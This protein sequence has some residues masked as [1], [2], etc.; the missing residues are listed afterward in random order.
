MDFYI[1]DLGNCQR[2]CPDNSISTN[3]QLYNTNGLGFSRAYYGIYSVNYDYKLVYGGTMLSYSSYESHDICLPVGCYIVQFRL[4]GTNPNDLLLEI[5]GDKFGYTET[6]YVCIDE[7]LQCTVTFLN[8]PTASPTLAIPT[9]VA[10]FAPTIGSSVA[11]SAIQTIS[12]CSSDEYNI[13]AEA[14]QSTIKESIASC[15]ISAGM[16]LFT[17]NINDFRVYPSPSNPLDLLEFNISYTL[18][19]PLSMNIPSTTLSSQLTNCVHSGNFTSYL[20]KFVSFDGPENLAE[21]TSSIISVRIIQS[22]SSVVDGGPSSSSSNSKSR[23][24]LLPK[25][26]GMIILIVLCLIIAGIGLFFAYQRYNNYIKIKDQKVALLSA[27]GNGDL[28]EHLV[29]SNDLLKV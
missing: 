14:G 11:V 15:F 29:S 3:V 17:S 6:K 2:Y 10:T 4:A 20:K 19:V 7:N 28:T 5:C 27:E 24:R 26:Y 18:I 1:N 16:S 25:P 21:A 12:G 8:L 13:D 9:S 23:A 22:E